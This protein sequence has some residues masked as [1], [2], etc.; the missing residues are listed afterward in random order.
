MP[1]SPIVIEEPFVEWGLDFIRMMNPISR[2]GHKWILMVTNYFMR[3]T[4]VVSLKNAIEIE[5]VNFLDELV[6]RFV[7]PKTIIFDNAQS[8]IGSGMSNFTLKHRVYLKT[9][10]NYYP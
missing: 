2:I 6:A 5:I 10:S 3:W 1:L 8:F 4:E 7:S 9:S